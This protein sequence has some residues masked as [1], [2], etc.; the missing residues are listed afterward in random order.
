M[1]IT[2]R[3][4]LEPRPI[5]VSE[6]VLE[7]LHR[8]LVSTRWPADA[9]NGD[10]YYGVKRSQ[11]QELVEYWIHSFDW[12]R[13][14]QA[15]NAYEHYQVQVNGV[16]VH[17]MRK[18][19]VGPKPVPLI[20]SHGWPWTFWHWSKVIDPLA[21]PAAFGGDAADAFDVIVPS[22]PGYGFS[23][24]LPNHPDMNFWKIADLW[25]T[26]MTDILGYTRYAAGGCD[27]GALVTGQLGHK[28]GSEL[29]G[30]HIGSALKLSFFNGERGWDLAAGRPIP[31]GIPESIR[32]QI[33]QM[34]RK[35]A[36]HLAVHVL[37]PGTLAYG[38]SDSPVGMLAWILERWDRWSDHKGNVENVFTKD[39]LLTHATIF[40]VNNAIETSM[41]IYANN[42]RYPWT[43]AHDRW[44]VV[45]APAGITFVGY[46]N[47][48][49][50]ITEN[51][52]KHFLESDRAPWYNHVNISAHE[53]GGHFIPWE[54]PD[55]WVEDLSRTFRGRR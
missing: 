7:D 21:D 16:P 18:A 15:I 17:F 33:L 32:S 26:L 22:L 6:E 5:R 9:G 46:E 3:F 36:S 19:G 40:W 4:S 37:D 38:L 47:P 30:I 43:P 2:D 13:S 28:Y 35:F 39:D 52:V 55:L 49:G 34:D 50:V 31:D 53:Q 11:L 41:R 44:P 45:E 10:G 20:L 8:R 12:R 48:P 27:V 42:N 54:A 25:H 51:R 1:E 24:P 29:Y 23:A 14:E